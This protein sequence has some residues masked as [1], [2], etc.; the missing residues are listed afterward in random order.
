VRRPGGPLLAAAALAA[1]LAALLAAVLAALLAAPARAQEEGAGNDYPT[2][3]VMGGLLIYSDMRAPMSLVT[4][5]AK[6]KGAE[7]LG[8]VK[9]EACQKGIAIPIAAS[10]R[11]TS[12]TGG[13]GDG[14]FEKVIGLIK[15]EH[16]GL[17]GIYDVRADMRYF[18]I[19][20]FYRKL[21]LAVTAR[22]FK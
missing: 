20:G 1:V 4:L 14:G 17:A 16:P 5:P 21:C 15:K 18:S 22:G 3:L 7:D 19:L 13:K 8:E 10:F 11:P 12:V 2:P 9:A 6:P